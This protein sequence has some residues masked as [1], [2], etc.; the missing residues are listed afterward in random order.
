MMN[1][2]RA[3]LFYKILNH[4]G[5]K[6]QWDSKDSTLCPIVPLVSLWFKK[7]APKTPRI[8]PVQKPNARPSAAAHDE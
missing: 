6:T 8:N 2:R 3:T 7:P 5:T 1:K 4:K